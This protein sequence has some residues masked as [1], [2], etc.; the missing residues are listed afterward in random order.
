MKAIAFM[1]PVAICA[2]FALL[3][4][5]GCETQMDPRFIITGA[6][7]RHSPE[8]KQEQARWD[9]LNASDG[10]FQLQCLSIPRPEGQG[11]ELSGLSL[12]T[13]N[14][15]CFCK[16]L[17]GKH[18]YA[19]ATARIFHLMRSF[20]SLQEYRQWR[21]DHRPIGNSQNFVLDFS[22]EPDARSGQFCLRSFEDIETHKISTF[23]HT[24]LRHKTWAHH[25]LLPEL[26]GSEVEVSYTEWGFPSD[27]ATALPADG[28]AFIFGVQISG[29][30][31][32]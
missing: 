18:H 26:P 8:Y 24:I 16:D 19:F 21:Y 20:A 10:P 29:T 25:F 5:L 17:A 13:S 15:I 27:V 30:G 2:A 14:Y 11:W 28:G 12:P 3:V 31:G 32:Q 6:I 9:S 22:I 4:G 7:D 1:A 23:T